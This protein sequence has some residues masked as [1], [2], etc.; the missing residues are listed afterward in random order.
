MSKFQK[1]LNSKKD[2]NSDYF[3]HVNMI[4]PKSKLSIFDSDMENF[5]EMYNDHILDKLTAKHME[6]EIKSEIKVAFDFAETSPFPKPDS[7]FQ[8]MFAEKITDSV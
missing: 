4:K 7:A 5:L 1:F 8:G 2:D 3:T 6:N